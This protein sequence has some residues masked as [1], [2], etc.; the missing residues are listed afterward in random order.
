M[1]PGWAG[2]VW[3][4]TLDREAASWLQSRGCC[5]LLFPTQNW[6]RQTFSEAVRASELRQIFSLNPGHF[7]PGKL[8]VTF[9]PYTDTQTKPA[10][11]TFHHFTVHTHSY[12]TLTTICDI[13]YNCCR[14][15]FHT[16]LTAKYKKFNWLFCC[17]LLFTCLCQQKQQQQRAT[18]DWKLVG[19]HSF[20][21]IKRRQL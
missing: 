6:T 12:C 4:P 5:V 8:L 15:H 16:Y 19:F 7:A 1:E 9:Y 11:L 3:A 14:C 10:F 2:A 13:W 18:R 20:Q 17:W 21:F